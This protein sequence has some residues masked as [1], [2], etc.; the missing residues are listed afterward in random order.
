MT[1]GEFDDLVAGDIVEN[2]DG[3][4]YSVAFAGG[5]YLVV[6]RLLVFATPPR[7]WNVVLRENERER[8]L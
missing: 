6:T 8:D 4:R 2:A 7:D 3:Q 5:E 1:Q